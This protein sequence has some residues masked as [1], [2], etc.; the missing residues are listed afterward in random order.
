MEKPFLDIFMI[1][2]IDRDD[3]AALLAKYLLW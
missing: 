2:E 3:F 1:G